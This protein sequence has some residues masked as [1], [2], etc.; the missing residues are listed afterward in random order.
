MNRHF[1]PPLMSGRYPDDMTVDSPAILGV[2]ECAKANEGMGGAA[3]YS[4]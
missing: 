1:K 2:A 4:V 3:A